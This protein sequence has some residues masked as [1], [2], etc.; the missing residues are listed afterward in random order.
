MVSNGGRV[1]PAALRPGET[2][3]VSAPASWVPGGVA[4]AAVSR[5]EAAGWRVRVEASAR[6]HEG[7]SGLS[8]RGRADEWNRLFADDD[9]RA[10]LC[11]R[12]GYGSAKMLPFLDFE[13]LARHPKLV[14]GFSDATALLAAL[15]ER[16]NLAV[17]HGPMASTLTEEKSTPETWERFLAGLADPF[18]P[19]PLGGALDPLSPGVAEGPLL[20]GNL[21]VL[22]SLVGT[23]WALQGDG[24]V[25]FL[26]EVGEKSYRVDRML[27]QLEASGLL[28]R[29][30][31][32]VF[33]QFVRCGADAGDPETDEV[34]A[35]WAAR[36]G[37]PVCKGLAAGHGRDNL[38]LPLGLPVRLDADAGRLTLL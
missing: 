5:L 13:R 18:R 24:A 32:V 7:F 26:E 37:K 3:S 8:D 15:T 19:G 6:G 10:I 29:V 25:L 16:A 33:G 23:P 28:A 17:V 9:V 36:L 14:I 27:W 31:A 20:G 22:A 11:A 34:L 2:L 30:Q 1:R 4:D 12:G 21:A 38:F 35:A